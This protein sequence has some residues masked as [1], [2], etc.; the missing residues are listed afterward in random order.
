MNKFMGTNITE[1]FAMYRTEGLVAIDVSK[2]Y[3][4]F[5]TNAERLTAE[6]RQK[7]GT[8]ETTKGYVLSFYSCSS[9]TSGLGGKVYSFGIKRNFEKIESFTNEIRSVIEFAEKSGFIKN[10]FGVSKS[11]PEMVFMS[12]KTGN[13]RTVELQIQS[14][15][16]QLAIVTAEKC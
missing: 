15:T 7:I 16:H 9:Q 11:V 4:A 14:K 5:S 10:T 1:V 6:Q 3:V 2:D 12:W 13:G 8:V